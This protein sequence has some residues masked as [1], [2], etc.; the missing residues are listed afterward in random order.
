MFCSRSPMLLPEIYVCTKNSSKQ[1]RD[2]PFLSSSPLNLPLS[3]DQLSY[4]VT[5]PILHTSLSAGRTAAR[6]ACP[7]SVTTTIPTHALAMIRTSTDQISVS[8]WRTIHVA[9]L[10]VFT[11]NDFTRARPLITLAVS[12]QAGSQ[13][14]A[15]LSIRWIVPGETQISQLMHLYSGTTEEQPVK[16]EA[17]IYL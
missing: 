6:W 2:L 5:H 4:H 11:V 12:A 13:S 10:T 14:T 3:L 9:T 1:R 7:V 8:I 15:H 16:L 17:W